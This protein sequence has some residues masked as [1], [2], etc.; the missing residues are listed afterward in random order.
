[1]NTPSLR[2]QEA[3]WNEFISAF[4][5]VLEDVQYPFSEKYGEPSPHVPRHWT[6]RMII[7][8]GMEGYCSH[9]RALL[10]IWDLMDTWPIG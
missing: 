8:M 2:A 4:P 9:E 1:M 10:M 5:A 3:I 6:I 7:F